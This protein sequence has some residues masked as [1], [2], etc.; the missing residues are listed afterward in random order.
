MLRNRSVPTDTLIPHIVYNDL[1]RAME[2][3][4]STF[5]F[6][7]HFHYGDPISGVQVH[8]GNA[9]L[10]L[11]EPGPDRK[12]PVDVHACTQMLTIFVEDIEPHF[13]RTKSAGAKI[14]ED[15]HETVYGELQ[16]AADDL[17]GHR[18]IFSRHA[19]DA[20]PSGWGAIVVNPV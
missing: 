4:N 17:E 7:E 5:G 1:P 6:A 2:W 3:L 15:L 19:R 20:E 9:W 13:E 14:V 8:L 16:Y 18:W 11:T 10:M 12:S